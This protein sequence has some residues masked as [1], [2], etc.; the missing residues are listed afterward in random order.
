MEA[1]MLGGQDAV[2][3]GRGIIITSSHCL[4]LL[5]V[6]VGGGDFCAIEQ[7]AGLFAKGLRFAQDIR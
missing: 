3:N 5:V 4:S 2:A 1:Q 7:P 6:N